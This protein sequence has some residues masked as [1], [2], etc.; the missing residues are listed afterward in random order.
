MM[1]AEDEKGG[2]EMA[3]EVQSFKFNGCDEKE[4]G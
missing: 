4:V 1:S 3:T 2:T